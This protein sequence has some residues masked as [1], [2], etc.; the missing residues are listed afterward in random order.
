MYVYI[1]GAMPCVCPRIIEH[2]A[3]PP[4]QLRETYLLL[5]LAHTVQNLSLKLSPE[6]FWGA[7]LFST[8]RVDKSGASSGG[9]GGGTGAAL[10]RSLGSADMAQER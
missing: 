1:Q 7:A 2:V 3:G 6:S 9:G 5:L 8:T 4:P 10:P